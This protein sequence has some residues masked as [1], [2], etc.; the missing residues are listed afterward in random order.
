MARTDPLLTTA[1][2][3]Y[4]TLPMDNQNQREG[5]EKGDWCPVVQS[6][7][8]EQTGGRVC[9]RLVWR[10]AVTMG[11]GWSVKPCISDI[12]RF[13]MIPGPH[14]LSDAKAIPRHVTLQTLYGTMT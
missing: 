7:G 9:W 6:I 10:S 8:Q 13:P 3:K 14:L 11:L 4:N 1:Q 5:K 2:H 12:Q